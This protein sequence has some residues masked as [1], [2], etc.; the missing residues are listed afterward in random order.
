MAGGMS[1]GAHIPTKR[2]R[3]KINQLTPRFQDAKDRKGELLCFLCAS[4]IFAPLRE[5]VCALPR[6]FHTFKPPGRACPDDLYRDVPSVEL[7][8]TTV[9]N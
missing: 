1:G 8:A 6:F 3:E 7:R 9:R 5:T 4:S 2:R